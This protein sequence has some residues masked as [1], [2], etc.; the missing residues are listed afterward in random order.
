M[1][2]IKLIILILSVTTFKN[3]V[4]GINFKEIKESFIVNEI[5]D[6]YGYLK[7]ITILKKY[8]NDTFEI[9]TYNKKIKIIMNIGFAKK[10]LEHLRNMEYMKNTII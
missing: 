10:K 5:K 8:Q 7:E 2:A 6:V 3:I 9:I 1:K 4:F